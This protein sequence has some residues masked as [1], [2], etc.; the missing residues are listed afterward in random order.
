MQW[1]VPLYADAAIESQ[2]RISYAH[3]CVEVDA[4]KPLLNEFIIDVMETSNPNLVR[5][6]I[7]I[8]VDYQWKPLVCE[9]CHVFGHST[10]RCSLSSK[11]PSQAPSKSSSKPIASQAWVMVGR[12]SSASTSTTPAGE[13]AG[14]ITLELGCPP[15]AAKMAS[16]DT[17]LENGN[18]PMAEENSLGDNIITQIAHAQVVPQVSTQVATNII[19]TISTQGKLVPVDSPLAVNAEPQSSDVSPNSATPE[20][21]SL[22]S[23]VRLDGTCGNHFLQMML[24]TRII[25]SFAQRGHLQSIFF[26]AKAQTRARQEWP[27]I[28]LLMN[29]AW[30]NIRGLSMPHKQEEVQSLVHDNKVSI[31]GIIETRVKRHNFPSIA[32]TLLRGWKAVSNHHYHHN[33]RIWI[34][35]NPDILDVDI[36]LT[37]S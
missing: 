17:L 15:M 3:I 11:Q 19:S 18:P 36:L 20:L 14:E 30:S 24:E 6:E 27:Q 25:S 28:S 16:T 37:S 13:Q 22:A 10:N 5:D 1:G 12:K 23:K 7:S 35:W 4:S 34:L 9:H 33:G 29:L 21:S 26:K 2:R 32:Q 31:I 8:R